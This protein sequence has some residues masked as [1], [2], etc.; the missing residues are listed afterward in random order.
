MS[1]VVVELGKSGMIGL[2]VIC[3]HHPVVGMGC[4]G[5]VALMSACEAN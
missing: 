3:K 1:E 2:L 4:K 5:I